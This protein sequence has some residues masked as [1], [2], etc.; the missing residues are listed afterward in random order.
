MKV[1]VRIGFGCHLTPYLPISATRDDLVQQQDES[2]NKFKDSSQY[3]GQ[4]E[5]KIEDE[6]YAGQDD[7]ATVK[8]GEETAEPPLPPDD[9][10]ASSWSEEQEETNEYDNQEVQEDE[11]EGDHDGIEGEAEAGWVHEA[12]DGDSAKDP[13]L[14]H[15]EYK[16]EN[17]GEYVHEDEFDPA[18]GEVPHSDEDAGDKVTGETRFYLNRS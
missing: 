9:A 12:H 6:V 5:E 7:L 11:L 18:E 8:D 1:V 3:D 4:L 14:E 2:D 17:E 15:H 16:P 10:D 13:A